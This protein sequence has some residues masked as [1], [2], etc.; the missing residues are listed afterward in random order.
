MYGN[1]YGMEHGHPVY[2]GHG[3]N[4][5]HGMGYPRR[6]GYRNF[7]LDI[8]FFHYMDGVIIVVI[9]ISGKPL[10]GYYGQGFTTG[11]QA[12]SVALRRGCLRF[13]HAFHQINSHEGKTRKTWYL[14]RF[15]TTNTPYVR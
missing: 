13:S 8:I 6:W 3:G 2:W 7:P 9:V 10:A 11:L 15:T 12:V 4:N 5:E 14:Q 1:G